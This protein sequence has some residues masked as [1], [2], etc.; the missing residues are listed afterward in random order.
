[1]RP[2]KGASTQPAGIESGRGPTAPPQRPAT[3]LGWPVFLWQRP[4]CGDDLRRRASRLADL[5]LHA[6]TLPSHGAAFLVCAAVLPGRA[7]GN[8]QALA[9]RK[10]RLLRRPGTALTILKARN[11]PAPARAWRPVAHAAQP[12]PSPILVAASRP[13]CR[14]VCSRSSSPPR[15]QARARASACPWRGRG[16]ELM[17]RTI[18]AAN[19]GGARGE[20]GAVLPPLLSL[21]PARGVQPAFSMGWSAA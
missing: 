12:E 6:L 17:S 18:T 3:P 10:L 15:R 13:R 20:E 19:H 7:A 14:T 16:M 21:A 5:P 4:C 8:A 1:M 11:L 2:S 9:A